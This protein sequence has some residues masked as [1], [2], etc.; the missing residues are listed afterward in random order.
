MEK[1]EVDIEE[2]TVSGKM[3]TDCADSIPR[4]CCEVRHCYVAKIV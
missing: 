2:M 4:D 1:V 3:E